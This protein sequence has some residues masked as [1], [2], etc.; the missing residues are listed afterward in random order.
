MW[1]G[2]TKEGQR[3]GGGRALAD[4]V[5]VGIVVIVLLFRA[6]VQLQDGRVPEVEDDTRSALTKTD[7]ARV[8]V[9]YCGR[10]DTD[11]TQQGEEAVGHQAVVAHAH[12]H[13]DR[14]GL[15]RRLHH[16]LHHLQQLAPL[17]QQRTPS[18]LRHGRHSPA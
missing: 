7:S 15:G 12:A 16:P 17:L 5:P 18:A 10:D 13:L 14:D 3:R 4:V 8:H 6:S 1:H 2:H 9:A 11:V